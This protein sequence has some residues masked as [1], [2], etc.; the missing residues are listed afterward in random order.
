M[1]C[2]DCGTTAVRVHGYHR[3]TVASTSNTYSVSAV[4][5]ALLALLADPGG[6][7]GQRV[8]HL[9]VYAL[10]GAGLT[11]PGFSIGGSGWGRLVLAG[12][13]AKRTANPQAQT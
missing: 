6:S 9:G 13:V 2:P 10:I 4:F 7:F 8:S 5:G 1:D 11:A 12:L 3:R